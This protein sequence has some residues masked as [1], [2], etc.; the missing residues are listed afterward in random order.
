MG[1]KWYEGGGGRQVRTERS[2]AV[3]AGR[4]K[5]GPHS[6]P[7]TGIIAFNCL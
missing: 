2:P 3:A 1:E 5:T 7:G 4:L 6:L